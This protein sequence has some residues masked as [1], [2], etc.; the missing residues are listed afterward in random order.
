MEF[1]SRGETRDRLCALYFLNVLDIGIT[2]QLVAVAAVE[3]DWMNYFSA[4]NALAELE[5]AGYVAAIPRHLNQVYRITPAGKEVLSYFVQQLPASLRADIDAYA[6]DNRERLRELTR[7]VTRMDK[8]P[9]GGYLVTLKVSDDDKPL[10]EIAL[11]VA[12]W[13]DAEHAM[14]A[15]R[16]K[17]GELYQKAIELL[18]LND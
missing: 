13:D 16:D 9:G 17:A 1:F 3:K 6:E 5:T 4:Q 14:N 2:E 18:V 12:T 8:L 15:W 7:C 11:T 10:L